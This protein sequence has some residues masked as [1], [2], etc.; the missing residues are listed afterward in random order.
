MTDQAETDTFAD[1]QK[2]GIADG[3]LTIRGFTEV[4]QAMGLEGMSTTADTTKSTSG[5]G[6]ITFDG[7]LKS[8]TGVTL[9]G[10]DANIVTIRNNG[11]TRFIF[12]AEGDLWLSG[13]IESLGGS[14]IAI[15]E[16]GADVNFRV[17]G[18]NNANLINADAGVFSGV[19]GIN[20]GST[21]NTA[22]FV[23]I[24]VPAIT[25]TSNSNFNKF[26]VHN[27]NAITIT[28]GTTS[29]L[30][31]GINIAEPNIT[32]SG[33]GVV[34]NSASL[35]IEAAATEAS[36]NYALFVDA[37]TTRLD[38]TLLGADNWA[39]GSAD[40]SVALAIN[41]SSITSTTTQYNLL[42][43]ATLSSAATA[44]GIG[45]QTQ[46][47]TAA[48]A[49]IMS[50]AYTFY[51]QNASAGAGSTITNQYGLYVENMTT[52]GTADYGVYI[53][54]ADTY[55]LWVDG[56]AVKFDSTLDVDGTATFNGS[57]ELGSDTSD[58]IS[59]NGIVDTNLTFI[60]EVARTIQIADSTT[61]DTAGAALT[62][63]GA[64]GAATNA[65]GGAISVIGGAGAG[66]GAG[67][68]LVLTGGA[69][70]A[71]GNGGAINITGGL[72]DTGTNGGAISIIGGGNSSSNAGGSVL[73][74]GGASTT[75]SSG[76]VTLRGGEGGTSTNG[77]A[78]TIRGGN[79]TGASSANGGVLSLTGGASV[80]GGTAGTVII[81]GGAGSGTAAGALVSVTTGAGGTTSG[82]SGA[83]TL[84]TGTTTAESTSASG[85]ITI[86]SGLGSNSTSTTAGGASGALTIRSQA[87]GTAATGTGGAG[88]ALSIVGGAGGTAS[89]AGTGG[90]G[91]TIAITAG[92]AGS[93][94]AG[95]GGAGGA[96]SLTAGAGALATAGGLV[97]IT[98]GAAGATGTGGAISLTTGAGGGTSG[99]SGALTLTTGSVTSG[100]SGAISINPGSVGNAQTGGG[101][102][103]TGGDVTANAAGSGT[104]GAVVIRGGNLNDIANTSIR[105]GTV[106]I[107]GGLSIGTIAGAAVNITGGALGGNG[108]QTAGAVNIAGG[109]TSAGGTGDVNGGA[110]NI[111]GGAAALSTATGGAVVIAGGAGGSIGAGPGGA[112]SLTTGAG[113]S[114]SG[115]SGIVLIA[116]GTTTASSTSATGAITIQTGAGSNSTLGTAGGASGAL[117]I[118]SQAG[119]TTA[120]GTGGAGGALSV[121]GGAGGNASGAGV[122][123][124][125]SSIAIT[126]GA[127]GSTTT[128]T[129]GAAG[130]I[131]L[132]AGAAGVPSGAGTGV[133]GGAIGLTA[134]AGSLALA[135]GAVNLTAG[136][137]GA[138][139]VGG[140]VTILGGASSSS[141]AGGAVT[142]AGGSGGNNNSGAVLVRGGEGASGTV[143]GGLLTLRGGNAFTDAGS[144]AT[145]GSVSITGGLGIG[146]SAAGVVTIAGGAGGTTS[147][148][149]AISLTTGAGGSTS[150]LSGALLLATGTTT[151]E[152][153]SA[154]GAIT[155]QSGLGSNSTLGTNGGA[156]GAVTLQ[157]QAGGTTAT[158]TGGAGGAL[159]VVGG[160]GGA[161]TGAG[162]GGAGASLNLIAGAGGN[163]ASSSG[164]SGGTINITAGTAGTGGNTTGGSV[165][166]TAG[167]AAQ[168]AGGIVLLAGSNVTN[169]TGGTISITSGS[170]KGSGGVGGAIA[171]AVGAPVSSSGSSSGGIL[172][173]TAGQG[174]DTGAGGA[175]SITSG[176]G[177]ATSGVSG[178]LALTT[179]AATSG[180]ATGTTTLSTGNATAANSGALTISTGTTTTSGDSGSITIQTGT[181]AGTAGSLFLGVGGANETTLTAAAFS[182]ST[183]DGNALGTTALM[184][185]D[186]FLASGGVINFNSDVTL[187]HATDTLTLAGAA[188]GYVFNDGNVYINDTSNASMTQGL[189]INQ[190]A[191]DN[192]IFALKSS[193]IAHGLTSVA[194]T[195][196]Y[197]RISKIDGGGGGTFIRSLTDVNDPYSVAIQIDAISRNNL[198]TTKTTTGSEGL[199]SF[200]AFQH[201]GAGALADVVANGNIFTIHALTGGSSLARALFD[202][203]GDLF[204]SGSFTPFTTDA[205]SLGTTALNW[206]DLFLDS[207]GVI[208]FDSGDVTLTHASNA[209]TISGVAGNSDAFK[210]SDGTVAY[211]TIDT[212]TGT[213]T[214]Y[215]HLFDAADLTLASA[216]NSVAS[217]ARFNAYT[218][219]L[220]GTTQAT[221]AQ[222][223]ILI[224]STT[225]AGDT[226]TVTVDKGNTISLAAPIEGTNVALTAA[227]AI[228]IAGTSGSPTNQYGLYIEDLTAGGSDYGIYVA[229]ADTYALWVDAGSTRLDGQLS[230]A[231]AIS[232]SSHTLFNP[233]FSPDT[234]TTGSILRIAGTLNAAVDLSAYNTR[235]SP[236]IVEAAS[237]NHALIAGLA[238]DTPSVTGGVATVTNTAG[239]YIQGASSATV[240]GANYALWVDSGVSAFGGNIVP[241]TSDGAALGTTA[242]QWGD[243]FLAEGGVINWDN[244]D[245]TITQTN[246]VLAVAGTTSTTFDST[247]TPAT[248][249]GAAL[250]TSS[251]MWS[252]LFLAS[253]GVINFNAGDVTVTHA[254]NK[255]SFAGATITNGYNF[256]AGIYNV[257]GHIWVGSDINPA[258]DTAESA[259]IFINNT[260][261]NPPDS[262]PTGFQDFYK[263]AY[264][265][266]AFTTSASGQLNALFVDGS[267]T[268]NWTS[269]ITTNGPN[270]ANYSYPRITAGATGTITA[271][272][273]YTADFNLRTGP[274][275]TNYYGYLSYGI[276]VVSGT[277]TNWYGFYAANPVSGATI[278]NQYGLYIET[279]TRGGTSNFALVT[280]GGN[281]VF[282]ES[283]ADAD[284]RIESN[285]NAD[286]FTIDAGVNSIGFG[287]A[288]N[289]R[290][291]S[292]FG[293]AGTHA[294]TS[295]ATLTNDAAYILI[296][297]SS[298]ANTSG[299]GNL[300]TVNITGGSLNP[301]D[302]STTGSAL[303]IAAPSEGGAGSFT[304]MASL[305]IESA[306]TGGATNNYAFWVDSGVSRFDG[307]VL[308][309]SDDAIDLGSNTLRWQD[310]YLGPS[311]IHIGT[312]TTD[313]GTLSYD[314]SSNTLNIGT[315]N[316]STLLASTSTS[317]G[318]TVRQTTVIGG[319][320]TLQVQAPG[321][322]ISY[323]TAVEATDAITGGGTSITKLD[324][325]RVVGVYSDNATSDLVAKVG[326]IVGNT[327]IWGGANTINNAAAGS[328]DHQNF[329]VSNMG[330]GKII[331]AYADATDT[332]GRVVACT[333]AEDDLTCG[334]EV[335]FNGAAAVSEVSVVGLDSTNFVVVFQDGDGTTDGTAI[336]GSTS[337]TTITM[338]D[339]EVDFD[340][341]SIADIDITALSTTAV[342][343]S[344]NDTTATDGEAIIGTV[345][346]GACAATCAISFGTAVAY[347]S[348]AGTQNFNAITA[349][350]ST[351]FVV[352]YNDTN[353]GSYGKAVAATVS[354]TTITFGSEYV[355]NPGSTGSVDISSFDSSTFV[356]TFKDTNS[357]DDGTSL[358]GT[359]SGTTLTF[360]S[361]YTFD[362]TAVTETSLSVATISANQFVNVYLDD[363]VDFWSIVGK[364]KQDTTLT[365][366]IQVTNSGGVIMAGSKVKAADES[367]NT[368]TLQND[369][370]FFFNMGADETWV[371][372]MYLNAT[373]TAASDFQF[374]WV[375]PSGGSMMAIGQTLQGSGGNVDVIVGNQ[376][377]TAG[378]GIPLQMN[379]VSGQVQ[380]HA[381]LKTGAI[382]GVAQF[383]W[384]PNA[385][386][387]AT[388]IKANSY[389]VTRTISAGADLAEWIPTKETNLAPGDILSVDPSNSVHAQKSQKAYD[390][391]ALGIVPTK[392]GEVLGTEKK[393]SNNTLMALAGRVP[394][395]VIIGDKPILSADPITTSM[396]PGFGMKATKVGQIVGKTL[397]GF[398]PTQ[399]SCGFAD[400]LADINWPLDNGS[401]NPKP[402]FRLPISS[403]DEN[404]QELISAYFPAVKDYVYVGKVMTLVNLSKFDPDDQRSNLADVSIT[405]V[406][407]GRLILAQNPTNTIYNV[408]SVDYGAIS[409]LGTFAQVIVG[410]LQSGAITTDNLAVNNITIAGK[411]ITHI[412]TQ[413]SDTQFEAS[414]SSTLTDGDLA[415]LTSNGDLDKTTTSYDKNLLGVATQL[416][417]EIK[418][419]TTGKKPVKVNT[420]NG[421][422]LIGDYLTSSS[423]PGIAMKATKTGQVVGRALEKFGC[424]PVQHALPSGVDTGSINIDSGSEAGMTNESNSGCQDD[425]TAVGKVM[426]FVN[427]SFADPGDFLASLSVDDV[428]NMIMPQVKMDKLVLNYEFNVTPPA[429]NSVLAY[430]STTSINGEITFGIDVAKSLQ[431]LEAKAIELETKVATQSGALADL[432]NNVAS[433][434]ASL[435]SSTV[436]LETAK[437][438]ISEASLRVASSS[439]LLAQQKDSLASLQND[440]SQLK[441]TP[442][443]SLL[444]TGSAQLADLTVASEATFSGRLTAYDVEISNNF[445][446]LG[447]TT[448]GNTLVAGNFTVDGTLAISGNSIN[449]YWSNADLSGILYL[450]NSPL[451]EGLDIF[452]GKVFIDPTGSIRAQSIVVAEYKVISG[453]T[454]GSGKVVAGTSS[455]DISNASVTDGSRILI[456]PTSSTNLV[457]A[458]TDKQVGTK[459]TVSTPA[460]TPSDINFD[461]WIINE[462][463]SSP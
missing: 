426:V 372:D 430:E 279:P 341:A 266:A 229:G 69:A 79:A 346:L 191:A 207:G 278:T 73:V 126:A 84:A 103:L 323:G 298:V 376:G 284:F 66:T 288:P 401:N 104:A 447:Q 157:S 238:I 269:S 449:S 295:S 231:D 237:G 168:I 451:A 453:K 52:G 425:P 344:Y 181:A 311:T 411:D 187:T 349:M 43:N 175:L 247:I 145:G 146:V 419:V 127:G 377:T 174:T 290:Y 452:N 293:G 80:A 263:I 345:T 45:I 246:N 138:T 40:D 111:T 382:G 394:T 291:F 148:G 22:N 354:G 188:S 120:T 314:T 305:Y 272:A 259:V 387:D 37:G 243:L 125:G 162:V 342:A 57:L 203:E 356:I 225:I 308:P 371:V 228:R 277:L 81:A 130:A 271:L 177:G 76:A 42:A 413:L 60:K 251:L 397:E 38:G 337:G 116:T 71:T 208:N 10:T 399:V 459:F 50:N 17:E 310:I 353:L 363:S 304:N 182:P 128:S 21:P 418:V 139:G 18:D 446:S 409:K 12:D 36:N 206:S 143:N 312:S 306:P 436:M 437:Q 431:N 65:A 361:E 152:S 160:A 86:Q 320:D 410:N 343:I 296:R 395:K 283:G 19:G 209:L 398:D 28:T 256:D 408:S 438:S 385:G 462:V 255:L 147:A 340:T 35:Y 2:R 123:G 59:L 239:L 396:I 264:T 190:G 373:I 357:S 325:N 149:G 381:T 276:S 412:L 124:A 368:T 158:G 383:Q 67:G 379:V 156:S 30:V 7:Y 44:A 205:G 326:V 89:G 406:V 234:S 367:I 328:H 392:P 1:F 41:A 95:T 281:V 313:E 445:K 391:A 223:T 194:E 153:T 254:A 184:W 287:A 351:S 141:S 302:A 455:V 164:G 336:V 282:N 180:S 212:R 154:S 140:A 374:T 29:A 240:S 108:I 423:V 432:Q 178:A 91:S 74:A 132:T 321:P 457:L 307:N 350:S 348:G 24:D 25:A 435:A 364:I 421:P 78:V 101:L 407:D 102:T 133:A 233:T 273:G 62:I 169:G 33:T 303:R 261:T 5:L 137:G 301:V 461:W 117:T 114:S 331:V 200:R 405:S 338:D 294:F 98:A 424:H 299:T 72:S 198:T 213:A 450:Q 195:D 463:S 155:I 161:A 106:S 226:A 268:Q 55:A 414:S 112:I 370:D 360:G 456:T 48:A 54:G 274:T 144:N 422:I 380:V 286:I 88:G 32:L 297:P 335:A 171:I 366:A 27:T 352:A 96:I 179:G 6:T 218:V 319:G 275:V 214:T 393:G 3:G 434:S 16:S 31:T 433:S 258:D 427:V 327:V 9:L 458:V 330:S 11:T 90:A 186:L 172:T 119:G 83:L 454:S 416:I 131:S 39:L 82:V 249:D 448:L 15:N 224:Q 34:T 197:F 309:G 151:A 68:A 118:R 358:T 289:S 53:A 64:A 58:L 386:S 189:T 176:A 359:L 165:S 94:T 300:H 216:S 241:D 192:E 440:V 129:G 402:C 318:T 400:S 232:A 87:G 441:L 235:I 355:F 51:A 220:T 26:S 115:V 166:I 136:A 201:D 121:V 185:S 429:Q 333:V 85:A 221:S 442:P 315:V 280:N 322:Q 199:I 270:S 109:T 159:S 46:V 61:T 444:A 257:G 215:A 443:S 196:T 339:T 167:N 107:N 204:I 13:D 142:V 253:A 56:G 100:T 122:G 244:G 75:G 460:Q 219:N 230:V 388:I 375:L 227:S 332:L 250:G 4:T 135:G 439:A 334:S 47:K 316:G 113:G 267:N 14:E 384:A 420:E 110:V 210:V 378:T 365:K 324:G 390:P 222:D 248:S 173:L 329:A 170:G 389:M 8:G 20:F 415:S 93:A 63:K 260:V 242:L 49:F 428:G 193:D 236:T 362:T 417:N 105:G 163:S 134:G 23:Q 369:N 245:V 150:G 99:S 317:T 404:T 77:G 202:A 292:D 265:S 252:D 92:A 262:Y 285:D 70:A 403:F 97:N 347:D 183:S 217:L 211:Y